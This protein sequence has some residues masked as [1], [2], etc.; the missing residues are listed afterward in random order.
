LA[1]N[2]IELFGPS[3]HGLDALDFIVG[4]VVYGHYALHGVVQDLLD[5]VR[6]HAERVESRGRGTPQIMRR[7]AGLICSRSHQRRSHACTPVSVAVPKISSRDSSWP[8]SNARDCR[9]SATQCA[10]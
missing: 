1:E 5:H 8:R 10:R 3:L 9:E 7:N 6:Q 2:A 4:A